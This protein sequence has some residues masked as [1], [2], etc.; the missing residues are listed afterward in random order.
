MSF[1]FYAALQQAKAE[2]KRKIASGVLTVDASA[3]AST[4][5][6]SNRKLSR[7]EC[8]GGDDNLADEFAE[9]DELMADDP[10]WTNSNNT[11]AGD[12]IF[13]NSTENET[14]N[15]QGI[16]VPPAAVAARPNDTDPTPGPTTTPDHVSGHTPGPAGN[17]IAIEAYINEPFEWEPSS[18]LCESKGVIDWNSH[19]VG[20]VPTLYYVRNFVSEDEESRMLQVAQR[21]PPSKWVHLSRRS[22]QMWGGTPDPQGMI[23][24]PLPHWL[25]AINMRLHTSGLFEECAP[26][27]VLL[28]KYLPGE[29]IMPHFD[30][31]LYV[32]RVAILSLGSSTVMN[33]Y[34]NYTDSKEEYV[35][36]LFLF[37][38]G[39]CALLSVCTVL[40][41]PPPSDIQCNPILSLRLV[42]ISTANLHRHFLQSLVH[43]SYSKMN[44]TLTIYMAYLNAPPTLLSSTAV[45]LQR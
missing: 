45:T 28:N 12:S 33:F 35:F 31:S 44:C 34:R 11:C 18:F 2:T 30:G 8:V 20:S 32:P 25:K 23:P 41:P 22:L 43:F 13:S 16:G 37:M 24:E 42:H 36:V 40:I 10:L 39:A 19:R 29:G 15:S 5:T 26:N 6:S 1:D 9:F 38:F 3:S 21:A 4:P 27:H 7:R 14:K 17:T